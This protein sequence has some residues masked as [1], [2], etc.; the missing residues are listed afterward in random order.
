MIQIDEAPIEFEKRCSNILSG[1]EVLDTNARLKDFWLFSIAQGWP[2]P[3]MRE[4]IAS[5][6]EGASWKSDRIIIGRSFLN[7]SAGDSTH[8]LSA[9]DMWQSFKCMLP[10]PI[11]EQTDEEYLDEHWQMVAEEVLRVTISPRKHSWR[12]LHQLRAVKMPL[13][14]E[15]L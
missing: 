13:H 8:I 3:E 12:P 14:Q 9:F 1:K 4:Y 15:L 5:C 6:V 2:H 11:P 7:L 10:S